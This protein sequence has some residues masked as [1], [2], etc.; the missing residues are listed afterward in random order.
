MNSGGQNNMAAVIRPGTE[1]DIAAVDQIY[2]HIL[3][4][5]ETGKMT[6]G[7]IRGIYPT[8]R[9]VVDA[10]Q[11]G[12]LY[13]M[14][15][16][17]EIVAAAR[18]DQIQVPAYREASWEY[19][20][21]DDQIMVLHTLVVDP[22]RSGKGYGKQF[23]KFY[24]DYALEHGCPYLRIDTNARNITARTMYAHMGFKEVGIVPCN[25]NGIPDVNL[26]CLEKKLRF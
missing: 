13:V 11:A 21:P 9:T 19:P 12:G 20:V 24:E 8:E 3:H 6:V 5:E 18:M 22:Y 16:E 4:M 7:W 14:E 1:R 15:D 25:F 10:L 26:V 23:V 2:D 17:G